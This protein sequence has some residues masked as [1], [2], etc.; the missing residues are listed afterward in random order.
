MFGSVEPTPSNYQISSKYCLFLADV[1][2]VQSPSPYDLQLPV[3][4]P[5]DT[6]EADFMA[7]G[8]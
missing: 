4:A 6:W 8:L 7:L 5:I 2:A 1:S 3:P